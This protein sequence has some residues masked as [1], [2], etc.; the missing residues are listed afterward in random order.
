MQQKSIDTAPAAPY[1]ESNM[2]TTDTQIPS[3]NPI[4]LWTKLVT[5]SLAHTSS[6][7]A[8]WAQLS[9]D[10]LAYG[11]QLSAEARKLGVE[12]MKKFSVA[13]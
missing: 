4:T 6:A 10:A 2:S 13:A 12:A 9:Q 5:E 1:L 7:V 11:H 8:T 3:F